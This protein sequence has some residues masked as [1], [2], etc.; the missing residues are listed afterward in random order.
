MVVD[1][2]PTAEQSHSEGRSNRF[3]ATAAE[4]TRSTSYFSNVKIQ[5]IKTVY[6]FGLENEFFESI[7]H[8]LVYLIAVAIE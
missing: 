1:K 5:I 3:T 8:T 4:A 7:S 2:R 6:F